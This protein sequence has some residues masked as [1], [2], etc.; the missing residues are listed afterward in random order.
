[1]K[2]D[3]E[4]QVGPRWVPDHDEVACGGQTPDTT[5]LGTRHQTL[6]GVRTLGNYGQR[7]WRLRGRLWRGPPADWGRHWLRHQ[8]ALSSSRAL[9]GVS[10]LED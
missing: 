10:L 5:T 1:M 6:G 9:Y 2:G 3:G 7:G 8:A 4:Q